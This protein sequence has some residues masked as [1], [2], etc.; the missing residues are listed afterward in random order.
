M[1]EYTT[2]V[3]DFASSTRNFK[4]DQ[5][6]AIS[7]PLSGFRDSLQTG[8]T[9]RRDAA[10]LHRRLPVGHFRYEIAGLRPDPFQGT[11]KFF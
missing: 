10:A 4:I 2:I 9:I 6:I 3:V 1:F 7:E 5:S 8:L 11:D